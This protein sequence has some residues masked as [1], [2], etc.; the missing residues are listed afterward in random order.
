MHFYC[1]ECDFIAL[2]F[3][4]EVE[5][6]M[7]FCAHI[8]CYHLCRPMCFFFFLPIFF[9][10]TTSAGRVHVGRWHVFY[11]FLLFFVRAMFK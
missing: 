7:A 11:L 8:D 1:Y 4:I 3:A 2:G 9:T 6:Q 10:E 5:V